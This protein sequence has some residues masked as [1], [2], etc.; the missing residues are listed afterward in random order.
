MRSRVGLTL[1]GAIA[2]G[3]A[4]LAVGA[5]G[6]MAQ[7]NGVFVDPDTPAGKEYALPLDTARRHA[8]GGQSR[9]TR[10]GDRP[11]LFGAGISRRGGAEDKVEAEDGG[12]STDETPSNAAR[13]S[14]SESGADDGAG[15][16][17]AVAKVIADSGG[18]PSPGVLT[19]L[20]AVGVLLVGGAVGMLLRSMR[21]P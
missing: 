16:R 4:S 11:A 10:D 7:H 15:A 2:I 6:A 1:T 21:Q 3:L 12:G 5:G 13:G 18:G 9:A 8:T 20:I 14:G 19:T 17:G